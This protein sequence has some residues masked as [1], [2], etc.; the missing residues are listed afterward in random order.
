MDKN[1]NQYESIARKI[2]SLHRLA[3]QG[4]AGEAENAR[5]L[6]DTL[7]S[8]YGISLDDVLEVDKKKWCIFKIGQNEDMLGL[9]AQCYAVVTGRRGSLSYKKVTRAKIAVELNMYQFAEIAAMFDWHYEN[10]KREKASM[11]KTF[12]EAYYMKHGLYAMAPSDDAKD[13]TLTPEDIERL[14]KAYMMSSQMSDR[15]YRKMLDEANNIER[16]PGGANRP[17]SVSA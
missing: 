6:I 2:R 10:F 12:M 15:T 9:F 3:E 17:C 13:K 7:L 1:S 16:T 8:K 14:R 5:R 11:M 4:V